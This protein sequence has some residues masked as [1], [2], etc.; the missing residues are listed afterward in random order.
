MYMQAGKPFFLFDA[1]LRFS[2]ASRVCI[3]YLLVV[4]R[5]S[6]TRTRIDQPFFLSLHFVA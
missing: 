1:G 5:T 4:K 2:I 3:V 6:H